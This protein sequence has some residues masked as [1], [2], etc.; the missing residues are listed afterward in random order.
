MN[1]E[2]LA[3]SNKI[4]NLIKP[5]L[6]EVSFVGRSNTG[7]SSLINALLNQKIARSSS[8]PGRT[9]GLVFF[10]IRPNLI[11]VDFPGFGYA[12]TSK[13]LQESWK[14]LAE[15]YY[16]ERRTHRGTVWIYDLRR[17]PDE[18]D[19]QMKE[20]LENFQKPF[21]FVMT[22]CDTL[23]R[24]QWALR[25]NKILATLEIPEERAVIFSSKTKE[26]AKSLWGKIEKIIL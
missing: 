12:K 11:F 6:P 10:K 21:L 5:S 13:L 8:T 1:I 4:E 2:F 3:H 26:G 18:L 20:W 23:G 7:K 24:G 14:D 25:K 17:D 9:Q 15:H 16:L 22:K 19:F